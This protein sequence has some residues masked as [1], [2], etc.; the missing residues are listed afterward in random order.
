M[1]VNYYCNHSF[2]VLATVIMIV[3][4]NCKTS[5]VQATG[6]QHLQVM[7]SPPPKKSFLLEKVFTAKC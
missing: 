5:I 1:I 7:A 3:N 2:M 4:Y 6:K